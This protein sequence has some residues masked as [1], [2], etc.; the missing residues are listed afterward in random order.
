MSKANVSHSFQN[1]N[2]GN[3]RLKF[4]IYTSCMCTEATIVNGDSRKGPFGMPGHSGLSSKIQSKQSG[5][6]KK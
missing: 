5:P 1:K 2:T 6:V 3:L 4:K